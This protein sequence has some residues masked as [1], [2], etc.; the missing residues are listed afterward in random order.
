MLNPLLKVPGAGAFKSLW[1]ETMYSEALLYLSLAAALL[2]ISY[3]LD[4]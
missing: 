3:I 2:A 1:L 4:F